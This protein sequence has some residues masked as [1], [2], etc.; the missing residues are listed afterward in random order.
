MTNEQ[1]KAL[2][3][4]RVLVKRKCGVAAMFNA[5]EVQKVLKGLLGIIDV[6]VPAEGYVPPKVHEVPVVSKDVQV[7]G[8]SL[9][10]MGPLK[11]HRK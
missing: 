10:T 5:P 6:N 7:D 2:E 8:E 4:A 3:D 11:R 1:E 9:P